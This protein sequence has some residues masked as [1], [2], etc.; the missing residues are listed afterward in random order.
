MIVNT[1]KYD[2]DAA[3]EHIDFVLR[4]LRQRSLFSI[5]QIRLKLPIW[6]QLIWLGPENYGGIEVPLNNNDEY[7]EDPDD[8][9]QCHDDHNKVQYE[10][11]VVENNAISNLSSDVPMDVT[12]ITTTATAMVSATIED[13]VHDDADNDADV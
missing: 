3:K 13:V 6:R 4:A 8:D 10:D 7:D 12:T 11:V 9:T 2:A 5:L 1:G